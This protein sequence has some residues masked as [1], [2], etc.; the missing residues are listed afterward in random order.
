MHRQFVP[1]K[2]P[3]LWALTAA[4]PSLGEKPFVQLTLISSAALTVTIQ[5]KRHDIVIQRKKWNGVTWDSFD[6]VSSQVVH[7]MPKQ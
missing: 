1:I 2:D 5:V 7:A 6:T 3:T 4:C